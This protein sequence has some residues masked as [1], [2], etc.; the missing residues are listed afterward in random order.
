MSLSIIVA[1]ASN[2]V[3]GGDNR[4]LWHLPDD[5]AYFKKRTMGRPV[6]MGRRTFESLPGILPGRP[7]YVLTGNRKAHFPEGVHVFHDVPSLVKSLPEGENF[8]IGGA[9]IYE[10][11]LPLADVMYITE[12]RKAF[13]GDASFPHFDR[14]EWKETERIPGTGA[15]PHDFVTYR[16]K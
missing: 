4:L 10:E 13:S 7:H 8:I 3:I 9:R 12:L 6:I 2:G 1:V 5:L 14:T 11:M 16:R 15:I